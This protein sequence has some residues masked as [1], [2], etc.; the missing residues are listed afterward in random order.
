M[1]LS[2]S[3]LLGDV[4]ALKARAFQSKKL[5]TNHFLEFESLMLS[6]S[7]SKNQV[8]G[9][10]FG[11]ECSGGNYLQNSLFHLW[12]HEVFL[13]RQILAK[14]TFHSFREVF[15]QSLIRQTEASYLLP[16]CI[17]VRKQIRFYISLYRVSAMR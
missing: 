8:C 4:L 11:I 5:V 6:K 1:M 9:H 17:F 12:F 3:C 2:K 13:S 16:A 14:I 7:G 15:L 10:R